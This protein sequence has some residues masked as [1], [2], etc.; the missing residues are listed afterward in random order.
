MLDA[1][2]ITAQ[3][4]TKWAGQRIIYKDITGSTN[5]D[6]AMAAKEGA[7]HGTLVVA[8][9]QDTGRG[10]R[11]RS[12]ATPSGSNIA[13]SLIVRP[14]IAVTDISMLTLVMGV[15]VAEAI[16]EC[17]G[18][19]DVFSLIKWPNDIVI[20]RKKICGMLTELHMKPDNTID[21]V[22]IGV[23][24]NVNMT[25]FPEEIREIAGSVLSET[26][27]RLDRSAL[28][29]TCMKKFEKNY[30]AFERTSDLS[31]I[32]ENYEARL[33]NKGERVRI[34]DPAGEF[35]A[36]GCGITDR[37]ALVVRSDDNRVHEIN[38]GE[39]SV[40]GLYTYA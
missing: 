19:R 13:M 28:V 14:M 23:G 20:S 34:L 33:V 31:E 1:E 10:S 16:D 11:G 5:D 22:V 30:E 18:K 15:S 26:G 3:L 6:A 25:E 7:P 40:R 37:G 39:V 32:R 17:L 35:E 29:A 9:R 2:H 8:D 21:D 12:W 36:I 27:T 38:A 4:A 24:I